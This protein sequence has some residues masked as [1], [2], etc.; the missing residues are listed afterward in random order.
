MA[1][2]VVEVFV[3]AVVAE[4]RRA[5]LGRAS[6]IASS[7]IY[8][9]CSSCSNVEQKNKPGGRA[10]Y[11]QRLLLEPKNNYWFLPPSECRKLFLQ[12]VSCWLPKAVAA[13][14]L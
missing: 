5:G 7:S 14:D 6:Y 8:S 3:V 9:I 2:Q 11:L 1:S 13:S 10:S 4:G 12:F